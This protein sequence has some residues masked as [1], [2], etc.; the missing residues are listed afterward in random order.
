MFR[1]NLVFVSADWAINICE[2]YA[3]QIL[4]EG[5]IEEAAIRVPDILNGEILSKL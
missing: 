4:F 3:T 5:E 1:G 2:L